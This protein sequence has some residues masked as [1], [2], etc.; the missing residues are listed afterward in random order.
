MPTRLAHKP[1][2]HKP[3][4]PKACAHAFVSRP[5]KIRLYRAKPEP[6]LRPGCPRTAEPGDEDRRFGLVV[7]DSWGKLVEVV[8]YDEIQFAKTDGVLRGMG[9]G[10]IGKTAAAPRKISAKG[11]S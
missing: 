6:K 2:S 4:S 9:L 5:N 8:K 1:H 3:N 7:P 10:G 11:L